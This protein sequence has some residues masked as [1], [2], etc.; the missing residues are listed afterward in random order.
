MRQEI[1]LSGLA[2]NQPVYRKT[3]LQVRQSLLLATERQ[4]RHAPLH[5]CAVFD[6]VDPIR[7]EIALAG[8]ALPDGHLKQFSPSI[9]SA[10]VVTTQLVQAKIRRDVLPDGVTLVA[11]NPPFPLLKFH[12]VRRKIP[13]V[14]D[15]AI[16]MK[17]Q[18]FLAD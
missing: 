15:M 3:R 5:G 7:D 8:F 2:E 6:R 10:L 16:R 13:V 17:I 1:L 9:A 12:R 18:T 11:M 14:D 4:H